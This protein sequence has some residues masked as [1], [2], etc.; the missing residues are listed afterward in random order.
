MKKMI[1]GIVLSILVCTGAKA[2][3]YFST[4]FDSYFPEI[5]YGG[6]TIKVCPHF[7]QFRECTIHSETG[8]TYKMYSYGLESYSQFPWLWCQTFSTH[9]D[10]RHPGVQNIAGTVICSVAHWGQEVTYQQYL[11][12]VEGD[13]IQYGDCGYYQ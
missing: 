6:A 13:T 2:E 8:K 1:C 12:P 9:K 3:V 4:E 5:W 10:D 7:P 11:F